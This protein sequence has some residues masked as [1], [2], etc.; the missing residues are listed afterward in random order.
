[1]GLVIIFTLVT[2]VAAIG[3]LRSLVRKNMLAV[4]FAGGTTAVFGW[5]V[6][7]TFI[8]MLNGHGVPTAH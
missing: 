1:M 2:I 6:V 3:T 5:F 7:M 4:F 8:A